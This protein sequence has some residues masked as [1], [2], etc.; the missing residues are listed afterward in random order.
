M[1]RDGLLIAAKSL[2]LIECLKPYCV[3]YALNDYNY[4]IL[5]EFNVKRWRNFKK[6]IKMTVKGAREFEKIHYKRQSF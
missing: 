2:K 3:N 6:A 4:T 1:R 5:M